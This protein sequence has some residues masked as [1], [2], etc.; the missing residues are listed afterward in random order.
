[1]QR[2]SVAAAARAEQY[3]AQQAYVRSQTA[4]AKSTETRDYETSYWY[5]RAEA[6]REQVL[7]DQHAYAE[8]VLLRLLNPAVPTYRPT[9][10]DDHA[11]D[12]ADG[13][14]GRDAHAS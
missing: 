5:W 13:A 2:E 10:H 6:M 7:G 9:V 3:M 4:M 8:Q 12:A 14:D 1:M 11:H